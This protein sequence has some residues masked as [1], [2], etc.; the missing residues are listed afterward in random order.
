[1]TQTSGISS[2]PDPAWHGTATEVYTR[3]IAAAARL[4][5]RP[6]EDLGTF[7]EDV[8]ALVPE[9]RA[10]FARSP[11]VFTYLFRAVQKGDP[12]RVEEAVHVFVDL[13]VSE[14]AERHFLR[15]SA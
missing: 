2:R 12:R 11:H 3:L 8:L 13:Y 7:A 10:R 9:L 1:M 5:E 6:A 4:A 14:F 15:P